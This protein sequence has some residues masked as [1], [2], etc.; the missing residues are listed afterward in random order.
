MRFKKGLQPELERRAR[1]P[2]FSSLWLSLCSLAIL[3]PLLTGDD[4]R[5]PCFGDLPRALPLLV[6]GELLLPF[7]SL[8]VSNAQ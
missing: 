8:S 6:S 2:L 3:P 4:R 7:F 1:S 5:R